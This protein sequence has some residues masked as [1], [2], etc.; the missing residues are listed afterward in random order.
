MS[1]KD[2]LEKN[3]FVWALAESDKANIALRK[4]NELLMNHNMALM[5][6]C[7][8]QASKI[9]ELHILLKLAHERLG[10]EFEVKEEFNP[11]TDVFQLAID[12]EV[13]QS[14]ANINVPNSIRQQLNQK[15]L[16]KQEMES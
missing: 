13:E 11:N 9:S 10:E 2:D 5:N 15:A 4:E 8:S 7:Q 12:T 16:M 14:I 3:P 6:K 1:N